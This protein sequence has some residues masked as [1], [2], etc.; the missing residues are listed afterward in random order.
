MTCNQLTAFSN[1]VTAQLDKTIPATQ[2][3]E[4]INDASRIQAEEDFLVRGHRAHEQPPRGVYP[5]R[6][7]RAIVPTRGKRSVMGKERR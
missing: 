5:G 1:E 4:L 2:G 7:P 6:T 3:D